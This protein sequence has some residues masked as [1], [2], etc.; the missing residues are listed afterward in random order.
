MRTDL[1][2]RIANLEKLLDP[3][4]LKANLVIASVYLA[5]YEILMAAIMDDRR[6]GRGVGPR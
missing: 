2:Q 5:T 6:D 3:Q 4:S 1:A